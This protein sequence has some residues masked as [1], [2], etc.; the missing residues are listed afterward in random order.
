MKNPVI[1]GLFLVWEVI[2]GQALAQSTASVEIPPDN[3]V[4]RHIGHCGASSLDPDSIRV[5]VWNTYKG[6]RENWEKDYLSMIPDHQLL[7]LQEAYLSPE[8]TKTFGARP[9]LAYE[10][11]VSFNM[12]SDRIPTGV[13]TASN[14]C[15]EIIQWLR[16][17]GRETIPG[18]ATPKVALLTT[19]GLKGT[20]ERLLVANLHALNF[21][22]TG[23]FEEQINQVLAA[24]A[25]HLGPIIFAGDFNTYTQTR[26]DYLVANCSKLGL[27]HVKFS[28]EKIFFGKILD[29]VF[30]RGLKV[31]ETSIWEQIESSDHKALDVELQLEKAN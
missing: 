15:P 31:K 10:M 28:N 21:V 14:N 7:L 12:S 3:Q 1:L 8:M 9:D 17:P 11:A 19:Y 29:H 13:A 16:S 2:I 22:T 24:L 18:F 23:T 26:F 5:L 20:A 4:L 30:V 27:I 25:Q 6:R